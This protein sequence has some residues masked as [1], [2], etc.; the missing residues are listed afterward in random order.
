MSPNID[1][2]TNRRNLIKG[3]TAAGGVAATGLWAKP[4]VNSVML[5]VHAKTSEDDDS[6]DF[7]GD[8]VSVLPE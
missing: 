5:P 1:E 6:E 8:I 2:I 7:S 3:L 4:V